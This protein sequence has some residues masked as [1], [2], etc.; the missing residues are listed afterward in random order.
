MGKRSRPNAELIVFSLLNYKKI[1]QVKVRTR[2]APSPTGYQHIGGI[3]TALFAYLFAKK[4]NGDLILRIEDTDQKR[5]QAGAEEYIIE[6]LKWLNVNPDEG[7]GFGGDHG[8]YRQSDRK[9]IY[10]EHVQKL[11]DGGHTY[12]AFDTPEEL[13][14]MR[15]RFS[16]AKSSVQ[17]YNAVTRGDMRNSLTMSADEV[18]AEMDKG[19]PYVIRIKLPENE[20]IV[21]T[22]LIRGNVTF[23]TNQ[24]DDKVMMKGDGLPTYHL[25]NVVDDR[26]MAVTH[27]IRGDEWLSSTPLHVFL[28]RCFGWEDQMPTFAHLPLMLSPD[29]NGKLSKRKGDKFGFPIFPLAYEDDRGETQPGYRELGYLPDAFTN[30]LMFQGWNPGT[31]QEIFS[32]EELVNVFSLDRVTKAGTKFDIKKAQWFNAEHLRA[33][34]NETLTNLIWEGKPEDV[35]CDKEQLSSLVEMMKERMTFPNDFWEQAD[36]LFALPKEY[37]AKTVRKKWNDDN[38]GHLMTLKSELSGLEDYNSANIET[39]IKSF[40]E[41]NGVSFGDILLPLR[42]MLTGVK[43]GPSVFDIAEFFGKE[44][45]N[46]R[47]DIAAKTFDEMNAVV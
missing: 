5:Y 1:H 44:E 32:R 9:A 24:M 13:N 46:K 31:E 3:R 18:K 34:D 22:D 45:V 20:N 10:Q 42:L 28:Y 29:G 37:D 14:A 7:V 33:L 6:S 47:F 16:K 11:I 23:N 21:V 19:T 41:D 15:D 12:Y 2:Y 39:T 26:T 25:A 27:V 17:Q 36:Y 38:K 43:G 35:N 4:H 40:I 8:P 30:F